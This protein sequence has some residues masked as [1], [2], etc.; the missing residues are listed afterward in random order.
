[1]LALPFTDTKPV[2]WLQQNEQPLRGT[3]SRDN[4]SEIISEIS[5]KKSML[6]LT[7]DGKPGGTFRTF[8]VWMSKRGGK[9]NKT[10]DEGL[11]GKVAFIGL[12]KDAFSF[13][14]VVWI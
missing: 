3:P 12:L 13:S 14:W 9:N 6:S 1:M 5:Q 11:P 4:S 10:I 2:R 7:E 8:F